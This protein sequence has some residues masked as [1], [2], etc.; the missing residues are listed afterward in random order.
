VESIKEEKRVAGL[1]ECSKPRLTHPIKQHWKPGVTI[2][3]ESKQVKGKVFREGER[4]SVTILY[5]EGLSKQHCWDCNV[6]HGA[7]EGGSACSTGGRESKKPGNEKERAV[8]HRREN[9]IQA[10]VLE[11]KD[12]NA[13]KPTLQ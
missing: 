2:L 1:K 12:Q 10:R 11:D 4:L 8:E 6:Q 9:N 7:G 5:C 3:A 13:V